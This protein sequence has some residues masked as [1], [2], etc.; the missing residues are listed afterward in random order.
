MTYLHVVFNFFVHVG[1][2]AQMDWECGNVLELYCI[3]T[4]IVSCR[5]FYLA[6][7][8]TREID[9]IPWHRLD[10]ASCIIGGVLKPCI[11]KFENFEDSPEKN[12]MSEL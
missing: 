3:G 4:G 8:F 1:A 11:S 12:C 5:R 2:N 10:L 7:L 6:A 9:R